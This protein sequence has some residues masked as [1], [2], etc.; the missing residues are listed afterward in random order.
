MERGRRVSDS[1]DDLPAAY[2]SDF[3]I[4]DGP[5]VASLEDTLY[6]VHVLESIFRRRETNARMVYLTVLRS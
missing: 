6:V 5:I 3:Q 2:L 4:E 1:Q